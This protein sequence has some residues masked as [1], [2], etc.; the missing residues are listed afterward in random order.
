MRGSTWHQ[1]LL[2]HPGKKCRWAG[3]IGKRPQDP[4]RGVAVDVNTRREAVWID[5]HAF[6][7]G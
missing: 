3:T 1:L 5:S 2:S 4:H 6:E 7:L